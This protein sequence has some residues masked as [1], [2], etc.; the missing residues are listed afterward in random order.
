VSHAGSA[1]RAAVAVLLATA[2]GVTAF[3][4]FGINITHPYG[5]MP[6]ILK[7]V[8]QMNPVMLG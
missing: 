5:G 2:S 1:G 8:D 3:A 7:S 6:S 4:V